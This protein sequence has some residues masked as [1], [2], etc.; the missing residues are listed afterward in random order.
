[1]E[2]MLHHLVL[3]SFINDSTRFGS[4]ST[5]HSG[6][7]SCTTA[8]PA[9]SATIHSWLVSLSMPS[10]SSPI[11]T[12]IYQWQHPLWLFFHLPQWY[13][14]IY[15][16]YPCHFS[17]WQ[18]LTRNSCTG[19]LQSICSHHCSLAVF[20]FC[21]LFWGLMHVGY[22]LFHTRYEVSFPLDGFPASL[23]HEV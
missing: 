18:F 7:A 11:F 3:L 12:V 10:V 17:N 16:L 22:K 9:T 21:P 13:Y 4:L 6:T 1:M 23:H 15:H 14:S 2:Y 19:T 5:Y 20:K 8:I